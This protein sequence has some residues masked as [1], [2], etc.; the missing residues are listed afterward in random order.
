MSLFLLLDLE[1]TG[2]D[3]ERNEIVEIAAMT[4]NEDTILDKFHTVVKPCENVVW[5]DQALE[6]H[7]SSGLKD[8]IDKATVSIQDADAMLVD[9]LKLTKGVYLM[10]NSVH[11][12]RGFI[13][14]YMPRTYA[15]LHYRQLDVTSVRLWHILMTG[16][17][18]HVEGPRPH[19]AKDDVTASLQQAVDMWKQVKT[20]K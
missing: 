8:E 7:R 12:D 6:M 19:R 16:I 13:K 14:K 9:E 4:I 3:P 10:G 20:N 18:P 5:A 1:T 2:L 11:F 17:D 15:S